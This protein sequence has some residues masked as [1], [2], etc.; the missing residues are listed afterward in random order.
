MLKNGAL[1]GVKV[2]DLSRLLP[3]PFCSMILA[4]HGADVIA[5][6]D[7]RFKADNLY[8]N[9]VNRNKRHI[10]LDLKK[11]EGQ[12]IFFRLVKDADIILEGFRPGVVNRLGVDY[13]TIREINPGV[14]YCSITGYGQDGPLRDVA[15]HDVNYLSTSGV[16]D[17]IGEAGKP[18][19]IPGAQFADIGGGSFNA[20]IGILLALYARQTTGKGQYID[21]SMTDCMLGFLTVPHFFKMVSGKKDERSDSILSH[22]FACY[23]TYETADNKYL[24]IGAVENRFW[25]NLCENFQVP[26]YSSLQYDEKMKNEIIEFFRTAFKTKT[27]LEWDE[28]LKDL[29]V[30]FSKV[31]TL[32][33][34]FSDPLFLERKMVMEMELKDGKTFE[35]FGIPVKLSETPGSLRTPPDDFGGSTEVVLAEIGYTDEEIKT[36]IGD[37]IVFRK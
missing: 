1:S 11:E 28:R 3:G 10:S 16:L 6:E 9:S 26:E 5:V 24:A 7:R 19:S 13:E 18:P 12:E 29:E 21:I 31:K 4:D 32:D 33:D 27:L 15:G 14:I 30:C 25:K 17:L 37:K 20:V 36:F 34:I 35:T 23:N 2:V 22:R 8:F